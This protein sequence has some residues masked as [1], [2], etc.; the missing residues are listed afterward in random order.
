MDA[1]DFSEIQVPTPTPE[2]V[3]QQYEALNQQLAIATDA[4]TAMAV[5]A[6][7]DQL[8]RRLDTWQNLT[9]LQ[10][11]RDTRDADAKAAL[12]YCDELRPKLTELEVAMK[13]RLLDG[14]WL[15][16]IRQRFGDQVIALWQSHVLTYEPA[17]E[18]AM[19]R[20]AKIGNDYTELLAS[21][22]F[23]FRGETTN[24]EGIRKYLVDADRQTRHD[25]AEMLWSWFASQR[26]PLDTLYDEQVK[27]RDSMARTLGFEN[28]I[29]L[30][31]KRMNRV[32]YDLHDVERYRAAVR[33]QVVP[34]ATELRKRQAQQLGV[35]QLMFWDE[36]IHDP[37]GNPK[38][39]GDH[40][41]M[42]DRAKEMF[43]AMGGGLGEF[44]HMM[45]RCHLMD[46][47]NRPTKA[48]GGFCTDFPAFG[49]PY[50]YANFNGTKG[51]VEV[52]THEIGHAFQSYCSRHQPLCDYLFPTY[53]SCEI[54]SM[55]L[56]FLT[57]PEMERFFGDGAERFRRIHLIQSLL[58]LPYGVA[59]DHFQHLVYAQPNATPAER[60]AMWQEMERTYLPHRSYGDLPHVGDG[61]M[62]QLQR[63]IYLNPFYYI[64][65][66]LAQTCAL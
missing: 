33:D 28:F 5:V 6:D 65:Y 4:N 45:D 40:D 12:E 8:R 36:G 59:V 34:L 14:P 58:F 49:V 2:D 42:I 43:D 63:H 30:G 18:Q 9:H 17:I 51:D 1:V 35:D 20:E 44:F 38:P 61:G 46:L 16:E 62:W 52:F 10:F 64:D 32:D 29:G 39:Q 55:S 48:G 13:R 57:W 54:H 22:S 41:W 11:S 24:I 31:Y 19:V 37:T 21:A 15:G 23:E 50:I 7:W 53:E 3:R 66:T 27:L 60:R 47:K 26:E 25:A 56:E